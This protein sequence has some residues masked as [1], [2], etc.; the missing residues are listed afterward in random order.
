L[1]EESAVIIARD[2]QF[3]D[4]QALR[5]GACGACGARAACGTSLLDRF[6]GRR[7]LHLRVVNVLD[8]RIGEQV[9]IGVPETA[10][11]QAAV[12]AYL[13]PMTGFDPRCDPRT[14]DRDALR[15]FG[16]GAA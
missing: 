12:S 2:G 5:R 13:V 14:G 1:I 11:L 7:P 16:V 6:L 15:C 9:V 4:V 8:A 10:L 3:A